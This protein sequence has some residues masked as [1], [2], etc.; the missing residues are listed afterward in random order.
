MKWTE[1]T[2]GIIG[3]YTGQINDQGQPHGNGT[4]IYRE[5]STTT[6]IWENGVPVRPCSPS[7]PPQELQARPSPPSQNKTYIHNLKLGD[8]GHPRC[9]MPAFASQPLALE[10]INSLQT[11]DFAFILRS[12]GQWTYAILADRQE[13]FVLFVADAVGTTKALGK[14]HWATSIRLVNPAAAC[15]PGVKSGNT[16]SNK[17]VE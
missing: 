12:N 16:D 11:Y 2:S 3:K 14:N 4:L 13:Y 15:I 5:E 1:P 8:V 10:K 9:M 7:D 17:E 6:C